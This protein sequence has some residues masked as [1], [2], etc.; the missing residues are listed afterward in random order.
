MKD[1]L[2]A[3]FFAQGKFCVPYFW[4][5]IFLLLTVAIVLIR[6]LSPLGEHNKENISD[7]L[8]LG[9]LGFVVTWIGVYTWFSTR[10]R[11]K[12]NTW[13]GEDKRGEQ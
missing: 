5:S 12:P 11:R 3:F 13:D 7:S 2:K 8:I 9:M 4:I 1:V 10:D 6:I